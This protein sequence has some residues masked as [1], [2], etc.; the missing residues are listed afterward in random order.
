MRKKEKGHIHKEQI[1]KLEDAADVI[2]GVRNYLEEVL[3]LNSGYLSL[4]SNI[5]R[6]INTT[7]NLI[8][9]ELKTNGR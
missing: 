1:E 4:L 9:R 8:E 2:A 5:V 3:P 7:A 6:T